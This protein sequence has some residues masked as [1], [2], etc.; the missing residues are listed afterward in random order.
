MVLAAAHAQG[1]VHR[2][3]RP[4]N[5]FLMRSDYELLVKVLDSG[6]AKLREEGERADEEPGLT[7]TAAM[8]GTA[9]HTSPEQVEADFCAA[10]A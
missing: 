5:L 3:I 9:E 8:V 10:R 1:V 6:V 4:A 7:N 2:D